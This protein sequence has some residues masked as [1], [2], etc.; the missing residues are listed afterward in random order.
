MRDGAQHFGGEVR[1][2]DTWRTQNMDY[3]EN[4]DY[5]GRL[6]MIHI[7]KSDSLKPG[8]GALFLVVETNKK[9]VS[10]I[11]NDYGVQLI[12]KENN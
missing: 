7:Y 10:V 8:R 12:S 5:I 9:D 11:D 1:I 6:G 3:T 2:E 4:E